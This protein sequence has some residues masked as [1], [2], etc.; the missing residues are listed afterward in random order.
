M[1]LTI[2]TTVDALPTNDIKNPSRTWRAK[3]FGTCAL[4]GAEII[5]GMEVRS[6]EL[7]G[8]TLSP[9]LNSAYGA[10]AGNVSDTTRGVRH[11]KALTEAQIWRALDAGWTLTVWAKRDFTYPTHVG[12]CFAG[13]SYS[14]TPGS[15]WRVREDGKVLRMIRGAE[16]KPASRKQAQNWL[17][18]AL[19]NGGLI[20][21]T[22]QVEKTL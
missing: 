17:R 15:E 12:S 5:R 18:A 9:C 22:K 11:A 7:N 20:R 21:V 6:I 2:T 4:S 1:A 16:K 10:L 14:T 13:C 19:K 8:Q 3:H